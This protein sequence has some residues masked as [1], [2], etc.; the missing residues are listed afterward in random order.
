MSKTKIFLSTILF[1]ALA[2]SFTFFLRSRNNAHTWTSYSDPILRY[3]IEYP[4]DIVQF[5]EGGNYIYLSNHS[6]KHVA[7]LRWY[8]VDSAK[9]VDEL[10]AEHVSVVNEFNIPKMKLLDAL[11][12]PPIDA[13]SSDVAHERSFHFLSGG[14]AWELITDA[15]FISDNLAQEIVK[16]FRAAPTKEPYWAFVGKHTWKTYTNKKYGFAFDYP[17]DIQRDMVSVTEK[18]WQIAFDTYKVV[19]L[20]DI[21]VAPIETNTSSYSHMS[22]YAFLS[23]TTIAG[24]VVPIAKPLDS[25]HATLIHDGRSYQLSIYLPKADAERVLKSFRFF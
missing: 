10:N 7:L 25:I 22:A 3:T 19:S 5:S 12:I 2:V 18:P 16:R 11:Q 6:Q 1:F 15:R 13:T 8:Y 14:R 20:I 21:F 17:V 23:T 4:S 24:N 9:S